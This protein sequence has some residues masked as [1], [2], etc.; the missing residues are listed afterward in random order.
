MNDARRNSRRLPRNSLNS[1]FASNNNSGQT[2]RSA[3]GAVKRQFSFALRSN[4]EADDVKSE[5]AKAAIS[6]LRETLTNSLAGGLSIS[7]YLHELNN[8]GDPSRT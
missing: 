2:D 6:E 5:D 4:D 7:S 3:T 8:A 1:F